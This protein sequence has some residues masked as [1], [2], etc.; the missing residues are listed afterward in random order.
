MATEQKDTKSGY[1][2]FK[3]DDS[4]MRRWVP[5]LGNLCYRPQ[6]LSSIVQSFGI[7]GYNGM[8]S[9]DILK[10]V[11]ADGHKGIRSDKGGQGIAFQGTKHSPRE[12]GLGSL[13]FQLSQL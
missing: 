7:D 2:F 5:E 9:Q 4:N 10:R 8:L 6:M 11:L 1:F 12:L 3:Y 13:T